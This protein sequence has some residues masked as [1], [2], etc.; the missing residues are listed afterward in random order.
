MRMFNLS[1]LLYLIF[2]P[3]VFSNSLYI[4]NYCDKAVSIEVYDQATGIVPGM[5]GGETLASGK[6]T[7]IATTDWFKD[8]RV[9]LDTLPKGGDAFNYRDYAGN[10]QHIFRVYK[11]RS[12]DDLEEAFNE[13][14]GDYVR[15]H[16]KASSGDRLYL[17]EP[18]L[19]DYYKPKYSTDYQFWKLDFSTPAG[20]YI[21]HVDAAF[22]TS[23]YIHL[24]VG[25]NVWKFKASYKDSG[26]PY[27]VASGY[28]KLITEFMPGFPWLEVG[29]AAYYKDNKVYFFN[30][31]QYLR[32]DLNAKEVEPG[33][34]KSL[35]EWPDNIFD[36][37]TADGVQAAFSHKTGTMF[38]FFRKNVHVYK[39][40]FDN[41]R[42]MT[43]YNAPV[44]LAY[45]FANKKRASGNHPY[46][47]SGEGTWKA[48]DLPENMFS[49]TGE[50]CDGTLAG[51]WRGITK[52]DCQAS[53]WVM[54]NNRDWMPTAAVDCP[55]SCGGHG[56]AYFFFSADGSSQPRLV[57][58]F[59]YMPFSR[60]EY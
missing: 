30:G 58:K 40:P 22:K 54:F 11:G 9:V 37:I 44:Y 42:T 35:S 8:Y 36:D 3:V 39:D 5:W 21:E 33:Y 18:G 59:L 14:S 34:P 50:K 4:R 51:G 52:S 1:A 25:S 60:T 19:S 10:A 29:A 13:N 47:I 26:D 38:F 7:T 27:V 31:D 43:E 32:Y 53:N 28:P 55:E 49:S 16:V 12:P 24:V 2:V 48:R 17:C 57:I 15:W 6:W 41:G 45:D 20:V 56:H 23:G 46:R